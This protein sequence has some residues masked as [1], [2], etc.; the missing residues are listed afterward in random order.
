MFELIIQKLL[1]AKFSGRIKN[2]Q[3]SHVWFEVLIAVAIKIAIFWETAPCSPFTYELHGAV[4][5]KIS[6]FVHMSSCDQVP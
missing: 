6:T 1:S 4:S 2:M 3:I 5:Q